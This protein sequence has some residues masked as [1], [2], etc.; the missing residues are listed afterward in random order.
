MANPN[1]NRHNPVLVA[2]VVSMTGSVN[3][4]TGLRKVQPGSAKAVVRGSLAATLDKASVL[5]IVENTPKD[6][7]ITIYGWKA[8]AAGNTALTAAVAAVDVAWSAFGD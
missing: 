3:V 4:T 7:D 5:S 8:T 6:G 2:G 1:I